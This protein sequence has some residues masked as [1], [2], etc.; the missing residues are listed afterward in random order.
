MTSYLASLLGRAPKPNGP[1]HIA[2][3]ASFYTSPAVYELEKRALFSRMWI[4]VCHERFLDETGKY[5]L[6]DYAGMQFFVIRSKAGD[7]RAFFNACAHRAFPVLRPRQEGEKDVAVESGKVSIIACG[8]HGWSYSTNGDLAKAPG[9]DGIP[10]FEPKNHGLS[11]LRVHVDKNGFVYV[12]ADKSADALSWKAQFGVFEEQERLKRVDWDNY[13]YALSWGMESA[14]YNWKVLVDNYQEC[15]HGSITHPGFV[16]TTDLQTYTVTGKAGII[17]H[18]VKAK[19]EALLPGADPEKFAFNFITPSS[20]HTVTPIYFYTMKICPTGPRS[21]NVSFD[22]YRHKTCTDEQF[23][24][25]HKFFVQVETE[26]KML[27]AN[28]QKN[29]ERGNYNSGPLHPTRESGCIYFQ[30]WYVEHL[31]EH[32]TKEQAAGTEIRGGKSF[33]RG[34]PTDVDDF[35]AQVDACSGACGGGKEA[36]W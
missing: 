28:V 19:P 27:C 32:H 26:D 15:Y 33:Y 7:V 2:L 35:A 34:A 16:K 9:F 10:G 22:V 8:Y 36:E 13:D 18:Y 11:S 12:N 23:D 4:M 5:Q 20:S 17:E 30:K 29:L 31:K 3:P 6:V 21:C 1:E 14:P 24:E 25:A